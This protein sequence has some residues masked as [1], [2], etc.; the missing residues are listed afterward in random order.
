[1]V[2]FCYLVAKK[3][4]KVAIRVPKKINK[5]FRTKQ[6]LLESLLARLI[7][8]HCSAD[9]VDEEVN[10]DDIVDSRER[11]LIVQSLR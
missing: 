3:A 6:A 2:S 8:V 11:Y 5:L 7:I 10:V 9:D 4:K 1:M